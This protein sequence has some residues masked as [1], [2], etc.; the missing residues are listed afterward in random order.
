[1]KKF[2]CLFMCMAM[3]TMSYADPIDNVDGIESTDTLINQTLDEFTVT[4]FYRNAAPMLGST[5]NSEVILSSNYGQEPSWLFAQ[6]PS[7]FAF[8]DN[9]T[10]FGYG[11]FRIR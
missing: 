10:D 9:G 7:I 3:A 11:Y 2:I 6:M 5:I 4:S 8:S 1:M